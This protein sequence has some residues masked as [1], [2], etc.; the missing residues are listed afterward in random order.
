M[1]TETADILDEAANVIERNGWHRGFYYDRSV[2]LPPAE[3]P[4]CALGAVNVAMGSVDPVRP[5][6]IG[7]PAEVALERYLGVASVA[8]WNDDPDRIAAEVITALRD[9]AQAEREAAK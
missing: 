1:S 2:H 5:A 6:E 8:D 4:V 9:A 3:C 7:S